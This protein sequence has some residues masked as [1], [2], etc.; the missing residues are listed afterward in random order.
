V[1]G[2]EGEKR[3]GGPIRCRKIAREVVK[4]CGGESEEGKVSKTKY[5]ERWRQNVV[6]F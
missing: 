2:T 5:T 4:D 1:R 6:V 3:N